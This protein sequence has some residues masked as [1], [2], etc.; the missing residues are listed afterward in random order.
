M[1]LAA[2]R[3]W[4]GQSGFQHATSGEYAEFVRRRLPRRDSFNRVLL[5]R[6]RLVAHYPDLATWFRA[7]LAERVGRLVGEAPNQLTCRVSYEARAYFY[8]LALRRYAQ[9][10]YEWLIAIRRPDLWS[11][12][13]HTPLVPDVEELVERA[14]LLGYGASARDRLRPLLA[15]FY[16]HRPFESVEVIG[17]AEI[18]EFAA[19]VRAFGERTDRDAFFGTAERYEEV[20]RQHGTSLHLLRVVLYHRGQLA[21]QPRV[22]QPRVAVRPALPPAMAM[23][24]K[25]YVT[26]RGLT[27]RPRTVDKLEDGVRRFLVW[28]VGEYPEMA[29]LTEVTREHVLAYALALETTTGARTGQLLAANTKRG[30]LSVLAV[31]FQDVAAWGWP[32]VPGHPLL[33]AG[34]LPKMPRRV[35]RYIPEDELGRLMQAI[36]ALPCP[37]QRAAL[38]IAR[39]SGAR[40]GEVQRLALDCLDAYP[41]GTPR[42]HVPLGKTRTE[43]LVPLH[44]EAAAAIRALQSDRQGD[45]GL[46][47]DHTGHLTRALF[48]HYGKRYSCAYLFDTALWHACQTAGLLTADGRPTVTAH[49]FRHTVGTQLAER[50]ARLH[51]IMRV[52]GHA[53]ADMAL[54]YAQ[55]SDREVLK[56]YQ[57]VLGPGA[58]IAGPCAETL[59]S[60]HLPTEAVDWLKANFFKTELELGHCLRLPEEGPCE[61]DLYL[62]CAK[63]VTT[64]AHAPRLRNRRKREFELKEDATGHGWENEVARHCRTIQRIEQLLTELGEPF[65]ESVD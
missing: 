21:I 2:V 26:T 52:L 27:S 32:D 19:A 60:G 30:L 34:D 14:T 18:E 37:Y 50:G 58:I 13:S 11:F 12:L 16:L 62:T 36:R 43:R 63:F 4:S 8:F 47:D 7:S 55:I 33:G 44:E 20:I 45:R 1:S 61:C 24:L 5:A 54:V 35:P 65:D 48:L 57:A 28:L 53:S 42:L 64:Q 23:V 56:D 10:D 22:S 51:T 17:N 25:R 31:F 29:C 49:R 38:L 59:R 39:W 9:F 6:K 46:R 41:D 3:T 15:R 40:R